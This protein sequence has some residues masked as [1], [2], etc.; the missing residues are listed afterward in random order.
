MEQF[1]SICNQIAKLTKDSDRDYFSQ[2]FKTVINFGFTACFFWTKNENVFSKN[3]II[4]PL[5]K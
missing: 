1:K 2:L 4:R 3:L 5:K